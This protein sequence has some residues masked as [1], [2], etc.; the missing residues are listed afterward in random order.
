MNNFDKNKESGSKENF[1]KRLFLAIDIPEFVKDDIHKFVSILLGRDGQI[2]VLPSLNIHITLKFLGNVADDE[3][4]KIEEASIIAAG[5]FKRFEYGIGSE[6]GAF[7][8]K[9]KARVIFLGIGMGGDYICRIYDE[10]EKSLEGIKI[11]REKREFFAHITVARTKIIKDV[12][13]LLEDNRFDYGKKLECS[14][15]SLFESKLKSYGAEY[16]NL[17]NFSLK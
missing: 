4:K 11:N 16:I 2:R 5:K 7:P 17:C 6:L 8:S 14:E 13:K 10:L 12:S 9:K 3:I 1:G 15:I